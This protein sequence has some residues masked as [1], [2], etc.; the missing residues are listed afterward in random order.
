MWSTEFREKTAP[1]G[2]ASNRIVWSWDLLPLRWR[3]FR[4]DNKVREK[5]LMKTSSVSRRDFIR[6]TGLTAGLLLLAGLEAWAAR[7]LGFPLSSGGGQEDDQQLFFPPRDPKQWP[8]FREKL[9]A[10]RADVRK[11]IRYDDSLYIRADFNWVSSCFSCCFLMLNDA[12]FYVPSRGYSV[13]SFLNQAEREFGGF[14]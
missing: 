9:H 10:W 7:G 8:A 5:Q 1:A 11:R 3:R 14:D 6:F 13:D 12:R 2:C 4:M